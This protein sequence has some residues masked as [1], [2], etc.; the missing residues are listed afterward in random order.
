ML[1]SIRN[2]DYVVLL[3]CDLQATRRFYHDVMGFRIYRD[4]G[5]WV[6]F[7]VGATLL[8]LRPRGRPYDGPPCPEMAGVQLAFRVAPD[9]VLPCYE[10]LAAKGVEML[11]GVEDRASGHRTIFFRDPEGNVLEIYAELAAPDFPR[12]PE[13]GVRSATA[14]RGKP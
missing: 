8:A 5:D 9:Q 13:E 2:L 4:W 11:E 14:P 7:R 6:E 12:T 10:E 3:C 1:G